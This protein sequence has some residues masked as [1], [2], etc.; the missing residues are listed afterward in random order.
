MKRS[1]HFS[2]NIRDGFVKR[3][4]AFNVLFFFV[5]IQAEFLLLLWTSICRW[6][7]MLLR[8]NVLVVYH[9]SDVSVSV[10]D[11]GHDADGGGDAD[12]AAVDPGVRLEDGAAVERLDRAEVVLHPDLVLGH[13]AE[14]PQLPV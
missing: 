8:P 13:L 7:Y 5:N 12:R 9:V 1:I 6:Y 2:S 14:P 3:L 11:K 4:G 10:G